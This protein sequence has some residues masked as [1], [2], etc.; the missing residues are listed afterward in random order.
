MRFAIICL[1][2][3]P[4]VEHYKPF[5][6]LYGKQITEEYQP[7]LKEVSEKSHVM[8]FSSRA[9]KNTKKTIKCKERDEPN[10]SKEEKL[11]RELEDH[12]YTLGLSFDTIGGYK[13][14]SLE[15]DPCQKK[16][17]LSFPD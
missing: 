4:H 16:H 11:K 15:L 10:R 5:D 2:H 13:Y 9:A 8:P 1:I 17:Q 7:S 12:Y 14:L 6:D 3:Y